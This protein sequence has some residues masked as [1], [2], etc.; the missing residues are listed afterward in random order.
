MEAE[1]SHLGRLLERPEKPFIAILGGAKVSDK[2]ELVENLLPRVDGFLVGGAMA[3]AFLQARG[4]ATG[5]SL[6]EED[7]V[8]LA[9]E[10]I[11]RTAAAGK[12]M[13]LPRITSSPSVGTTTTSAR[14]PARRSA[15][16]RPRWTSAED[17]RAVR[18]GDRQGQD[19]SVNGP[20]GRF[21][22]DAFAAGTVRSAKLWRHRR[23]SRSSAAGT[24]PRP[25]R[26]STSRTR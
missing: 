10:L 15:T 12:L 26:S 2:I 14:A 17:D 5:R 8:A 19:R 23:R 3:Y 16:T 13:I 1:L 22:V 9:G 11:A 7:K 25:S 4:I 20:V 21:E 24:P 6:V 18:G